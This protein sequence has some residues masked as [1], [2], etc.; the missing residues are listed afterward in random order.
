M[1]EKKTIYSNLNS[2]LNLDGLSDES[3]AKSQ[4]IVIRGNSPE[5]IYLEDAADILLAQTLFD[6][7]D[8]YSENAL[9]YGI[10]VNSC[11]NT[12]PCMHCL[13]KNLCLSLSSDFPYNYSVWSH[14]Q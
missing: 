10:S 1:A 7:L 2:F 14:P 3:N 13:K 4:K 11:I 6:W 5:E 9:V 8:Y 12:M